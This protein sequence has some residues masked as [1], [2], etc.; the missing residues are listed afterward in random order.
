MVYLI[1]N[2]DEIKD[3]IPRLL[4]ID[5]YT[6]FIDPLINQELAAP[7]RELQNIFN[8]RRGMSFRR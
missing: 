6:T 1:R 3:P 8:P 5:P 2:T 4:G 7:A